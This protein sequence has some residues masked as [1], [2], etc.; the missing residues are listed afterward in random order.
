MPDRSIYDDTNSD[1]ALHSRLVLHRVNS[2][3]PAKAGAEK[4]WIPPYRVRGRLSRARNDKLWKTYVP[5]YSV[6]FSCR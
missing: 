2:I 3:G 4:D 5:V 6:S 1:K